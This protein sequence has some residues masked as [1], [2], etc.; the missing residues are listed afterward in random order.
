MSES[1]LTARMT[2]RNK[3]IVEQAADL[4]GV[5]VTEFTTTAILD[6]AGDIVLQ[7]QRRLDSIARQDELHRILKELEDM[8]NHENPPEPEHQL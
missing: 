1:R 2:Q 4:E 3:S 8:I 7:E 6:K 5:T